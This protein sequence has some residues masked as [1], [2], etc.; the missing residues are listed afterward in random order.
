M[1]S[2]FSAPKQQ[3]VERLI[4]AWWISSHRRGGGNQP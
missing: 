4:V 1:A 2:E 3:I